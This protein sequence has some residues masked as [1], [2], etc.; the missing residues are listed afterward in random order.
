MGTGCI[1]PERSEGTDI[2]KYYSGG[3]NDNKD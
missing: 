3:A 2:R 1:Y